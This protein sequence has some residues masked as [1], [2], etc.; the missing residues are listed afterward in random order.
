VR[1]TCLL[2]AIAYNADFSRWVLGDPLAVT[3]LP[4][5]TGL[6]D[7]GG[8]VAIEPAAGPYLSNE[9]AAA[10]ATAL[11]GWT[12]LQWLGDAT[13]TNPALS[14]AMT[15][16]KTVKAIFGTPLSTSIVG[17]GALVVEPLA[18][19]YPFGSSVRLTAVPQTG[20]YLAFWANVASGMTNNPLTFTVTKTNPTITAVFTLLSGP[21]TNALTVI[22]NGQGQ[23]TFT[24]AGNRFPRNTNV[25]LLAVPDV[26]QDFLGWSEAASGNENRLVV[27]MTSNVVL[28]ANFTKRPRLHGEGYP[29]LL[30][31]DGF[32][33]TLTGEWGTPYRIDGSTNLVEW[34]ALTTLTNWFGTVQFTDGEGTNLPCRFYRAVGSS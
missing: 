31:Q 28:T 26:G 33:V 27:T 5:L 24:P 20:S 4:T 3:I 6:T 15:R 34:I 14:I 2:R 9:L 7:G 18:A 13:G 23:V 11:P 16:N 19:W 17:N 29:E 1:K 32:R 25:V 12:F 22:P 30:S 21:Q 10:T 8:N